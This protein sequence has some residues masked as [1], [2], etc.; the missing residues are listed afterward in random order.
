MERII[1]ELW[2]RVTVRESHFRIPQ[3]LFAPRNI[4]V[5]S[6]CTVL[7]DR[8][9]ELLPTWMEHKDQGDQIEVKVRLGCLL[10]F[11]KRDAAK[12]VLN[13][14]KFKELNP[15]QDFGTQFSR[16]LNPQKGV[17]RTILT[18]ITQSGVWTAKD[19]EAST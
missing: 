13:K 10:Y 18:G 9:Q 17:V 5:E 7:V 1:R 19:L 8:F 16:H 11:G 12:G 3:A 14:E 2:W 6:D 4:S 15:K